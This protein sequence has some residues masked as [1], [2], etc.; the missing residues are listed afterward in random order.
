MIFVSCT[1]TYG[2]VDTSCQC[3]GIVEIGSASDTLAFTALVISTD[4]KSKPIQKPIKR[5]KL[6]FVQHTPS[7][8]ALLQNYAER[9]RNFLNSISLFEY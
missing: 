1:V 2:Y 9:V 3:R 5:L 4:N 8:S 7:E 6:I